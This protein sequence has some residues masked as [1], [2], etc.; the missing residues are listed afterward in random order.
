MHNFTWS[1]DGLILGN[2]EDGNALACG[3]EV[4]CNASSLYFNRIGVNDSGNYSVTLVSHLDNGER[5]TS[6][7]YF[8]LQILCM[9]RY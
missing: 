7:G 9:F 3:N 6:H 4:R 2:S 1:K 8:I 5:W